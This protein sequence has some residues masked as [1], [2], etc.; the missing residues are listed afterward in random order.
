MARARHIYLTNAH[1]KQMSIESEVF[2]RAHIVIKSLPGA[3]FTQTTHGW[4]RTT[5][6]MAGA[7]RA[8]INVSND[9][10]V[11]GTVYDN[12]TGE[13]FLPMRV[14]NMAD[15]FIGR[16][17][18][19][20][21]KIL[22]DIRAIVTTKNYFVG[23]QANRIAEQIVQKYATR[24]VF[25]WEK[26]PE[27]GVFKHDGNKKWFALFMNLDIAKLDKRHSG[28]VDIV[29][30]KLAPDAI[31]KLVKKRGFYPAYHMN[32]VS[33]ITIILDDTLSDDCVMELVDES[34]NLT[35]G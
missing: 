30:V 20:Y 3:G 21:E 9:G 26:Y 12:A 16:V 18:D 23:P 34:F 35:N 22:I 8:V 33:W 7:F 10:T 6:F 32:K 11:T 13:E 2:K 4:T 27:F 25:P 1:I 5:N 28:A 24:P 15:G 29:N 31:K 17:K 19:E 14:E